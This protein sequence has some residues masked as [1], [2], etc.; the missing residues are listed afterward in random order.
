M[1]I[2]VIIAKSQEHL[3]ACFEIRYQVFV[4]EL[5]VYPSKNFLFNRE[6]DA[7]DTVA[8][9]TN[10]LAL[11][12]G[13]PAATVRLLRRNS[14]IAA[15]NSWDYGITLERHFCIP[16]GMPDQLAELPRS[17]V[18]RKYRHLMIAPLV[19]AKALQIA[20]YDGI[21]TFVAEVFPETDNVQL[22]AHYYELLR[23]VGLVSENY[24]FVPRN[25][26]CQ[27]QINSLAQSKEIHSRREIIKRMPHA[28]RSFL[29]L[30]AVVC[31]K[32]IHVEAFNGISIPI[33]WSL[34]TLDTN[35]KKI[36]HKLLSSVSQCTI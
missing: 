28:L 31:G 24:N 20:E 18:L 16:Q 21:Q 15:R 11:V 5:K 12:D 7:L 10:I 23:N 6:S 30:G 36:V 22:V 2:E 34:E 32:P 8:T 4:D 29:H 3:D 17:S 35:H 14:V 27:V 1:S 9:T 33:L 26:S 25:D 13:V 19:W